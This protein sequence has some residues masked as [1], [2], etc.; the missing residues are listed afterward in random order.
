MVRRESDQPIVLGD[1]RAAHMG[2]GLTEVRRW[3][4]KHCPAKK[5]RKSNANLTASISNDG[6]RKRLFLSR[7]LIRK[8]V[9]SKSPVLKNGTPGSVRGRSGNRP[10]YRDVRQ[11]KLGASCRV[12]VPAE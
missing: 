1:G 8:R 4:R 6:L 2:K 7:R 3:H 12:K 11:A 5:G 9:L 10:S